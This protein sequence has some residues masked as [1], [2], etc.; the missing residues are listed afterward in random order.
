MQLRSNT[1]SSGVVD[2][3]QQI[4]DLVDIAKGGDFKNCVAVGKDIF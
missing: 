2:Q 1:T 3:L 4:K